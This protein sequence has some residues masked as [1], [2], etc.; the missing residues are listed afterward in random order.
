LADFET[1]L[2]L[3]EDTAIFDAEDFEGEAVGD[4]EGLLDLMELEETLEAE[5]D[6]LLGATLLDAAFDKTAEE[7]L[8]VEL[9]LGVAFGAADWVGLDEAAE[10]LDDWK[11]ERWPFYVDER[12]W[13]DR[14]S[15][16]AEPEMFIEI[17]SA[18]SS[19]SRRAG[20]EVSSSE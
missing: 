12:T 7:R 10:A 13:S 16:P 8:L 14:P 20:Y 15:W 11:Y 17:P 5:D 2:R 19:I 3:G 1:E 9:D 18:L 6:A 4:A